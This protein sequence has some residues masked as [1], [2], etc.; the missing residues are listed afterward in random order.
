MKRYIAIISIIITA[1]LLSCEK[2][3][4]VEPTYFISGDQAITDKN[5][6]ENAL[7]GVYD[8]LQQ[9]G[10]YGLHL[11]IIPGVAADNLDWRGTTQDY[12]QF[13]NNNL[14]ADNFIIESI[15]ASH[16]DALNRLNL[17]LVNLPDITDMTNQEKNDVSA[18]CYFIRALLH[19]NLVRMFGAVP[20]K[21]VPTTDLESNVNVGRSSV[22][23]VYNQINRD[24]E[25]AAG[26]ILGTNPG[27]ATNSAVTA[28]QAKVALYQGD[29]AKA[30][31]KATEVI[32]SGF[33]LEGNFAD[34]FTQSVSAEAIFVIL[35]NEQD[36]N[37][38]AEYFYPSSS[39]GGRYEIAPSQDLID[40]FD[41]TDERLSG[42]IAGNPPYGAK[43]NDL[44]TRANNVHCIRLAEMYLIRA[45]AET[46]LQGSVQSI[47]NDINILR[48]RAEMPFIETGEYDEL[49]LVIE[50]EHRREF[51]FEGHRWFE[52]VRTGRAIE[53]LPTVTNENQLLFPI[54][55]SEIQNNSSPDMYQNPGY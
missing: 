16:Y 47:R 46:R 21:T 14:L 12:G 48:E 27:F 34:L 38:L 25:E 5:G 26:K 52:L 24:L 10:L 45:E 28:L 9:N 6:A 53:V 4:E 51:A 22:F 55:Q 23:E 15:W 37:R 2:I 39:V 1:T 29:Y 13:E 17:I 19:F 35:F 54:P 32:N 7:I 8:A 42:S 11:P 33:E 41:E 3:L 50:D 20:V 18:Q 31:D 40:S 36:G 43:Y 49:L 44:V 30:R